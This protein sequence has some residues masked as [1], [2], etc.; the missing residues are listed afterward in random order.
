MGL[1]GRRAMSHEPSVQPWRSFTPGKQQRSEGSGGRLPQTWTTGGWNIWWRVFWKGRE[2]C[3]FWLILVTV[4][5]VRSGWFAAWWLNW[6]SA[7]A[8][9]FI[10]TEPVT[11]DWHPDFNPV[12]LTAPT[13]PPS[14]SSSSVPRWFETSSLWCTFHV[15]TR[16]HYLCA[17]HCWRKKLL[18]FPPHTYL[19]SSCYCSSSG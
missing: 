4:F 6:H 9:G 12:H 5:G 18:F 10:T 3:L 7:Q 1:G 11:A 14:S 2:M 19:P 8:G 16:L 13:R 15:S 17:A